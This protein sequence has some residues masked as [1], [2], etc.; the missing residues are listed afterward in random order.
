[1]AMVSRKGNPAAHQVNEQGFRAYAG[2]GL[3]PKDGPVLAAA[4]VVVAQQQR[5]HDKHAPTEEQDR[6][7]HT[8]AHAVKA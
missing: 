7:L 1:M 2:S 8:L 3:H 4:A 5:E 6:H